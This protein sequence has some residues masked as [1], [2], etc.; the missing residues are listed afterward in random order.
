M[1]FINLKKRSV[2][3]AL[4]CPTVLCI[5]NFDGVHLGH[6]QLINA[7]LTKCNELT[8]TYPTIKTGAWFFDSNFYKN[9]VEIYS[10][11]E[12][13]DVFAS[14][15]L[16]YAIIAD[17]NKMKTL[18]P[19]DFVEKVLQEECKCVHAICGDNFRFGAKAAGDSI[20]LLELMKGHASIIPLLTENSTVISSTYIRALLSDGFIEK[21]NSLLSSNYS[22]T[23]PVVQGKQLGRKIGIPTINQNIKTKELLLKNGIYSSICTINGNKYFGVTNVGLRPT[24]DD[25]THK[26]I[27]THIIDFHD[28]CY[29]VKVKVEFISRIRDEIKFDSIEGLRTQIQKDIEITKQF[30]NNK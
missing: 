8:N 2:E 27:E 17:F 16:D 22:I 3:V 21:A 7:V 1:Q 9:T 26:N 5:G 20:A 25:G 24:V 10:L 19:K 13:L 23:E 6:R 15:G 18:S 29:G 4:S 11:D 28:D 30:F 12:K 14:L